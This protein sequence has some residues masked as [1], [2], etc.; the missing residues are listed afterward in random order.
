MNVSEFEKMFSYLKSF[1]LECE[2]EYKP[3]QEQARAIFTT[4]CLMD[5]IDADT[6][7]CDNM[8]MELWSEAAL[9]DA[10]VDF[11]EFENY[12]VGLIV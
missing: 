12:M 7:T 6:S 8:L 11:Y 5:N 9:K 2:W 1:M 4:I 10:G 3:F